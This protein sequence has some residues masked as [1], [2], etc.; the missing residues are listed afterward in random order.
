MS[1]SLS[2]HLQ[3]L[4]KLHRSQNDY[5][6]ALT[7]HHMN[8]YTQPPFPSGWPITPGMEPAPT[9][10]SKPLNWHCAKQSPEVRIRWSLPHSSGQVNGSL[11]L[12]FWL[13]RTSKKHKIAAILTPWISLTFAPV[14]GGVRN[15]RLRPTYSSHLLRTVGRPRAKIPSRRMFPVLLFWLTAFI[16]WI[17]RTR[18]TNNN[19]KEN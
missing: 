3:Q 19:T 6:H 1:S 14:Y 11:P 4:I 8:G 5:E 17:D 13:D 12:D 2:C 15:H 9:N 18:F 7:T 16:F 10:Y